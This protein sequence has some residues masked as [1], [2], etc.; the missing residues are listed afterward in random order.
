[1]FISRRNVNH[2]TS[3]IKIKE[4]CQKFIKEES[5]SMRKGFLKLALNSDKIDYL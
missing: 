5:N 4:I 2:S 1:M 3:E